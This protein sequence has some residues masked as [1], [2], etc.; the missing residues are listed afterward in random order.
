MATLLGDYWLNTGQGLPSSSLV[1]LVREFGFTD[2]AA[3]AAMSRLNRRGLIELT[4]VGRRTFYRNTPATE[5]RFVDRV[6]RVIAFGTGSTWD[7]MWTV[8]AF[9]L[10]EDRRDTRHLLRARL[11]WLG[12]APL[13]D[14]VWVSPTVPSGATIE[15]LREFGVNDMSV[16]RARDVGVD[17]H[18]RAL[19]N[20]WDLDKLRSVYEDFL[21]QTSSLLEV[22][23]E[24]DVDPAFALVA[25][26]RLMDS[27]RD[28]P[29]L[30][31]NLPLEVMPAGWPRPAARAAM[32]EAYD[33]L[34]P[35]AELRVRQIIAQDDVELARF[36]KAYTAAELANTPSGAAE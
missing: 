24:G 19:V 1:A 31:P 21:A 34:A 3:R 9:S 11:R 18:M 4:K 26:T 12:F 36:A 15:S 5:Q 30:D 35:L 20:A 28:F 7:G 22:I 17:A 29:T 33:S 14:G 6:N 32:L 25:R 8:V 16:M 23:G 10:S 2:G 13:Y 27:Y